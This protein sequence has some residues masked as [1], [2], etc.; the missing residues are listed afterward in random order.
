ML[1]QEKKNRALLAAFLVGLLTLAGG[2]VFATA[3]ISTMD[4]LAACIADANEAECELSDSFSFDRQLTITRD[5]TI[6]G[7]NKTLSRADGYAGGLFKVNAENTLTISE[8]T[9]DGG[10]PGWNRD[11]SKDA[12][13]FRF[14]ATGDRAYGQYTVNI[15]END[16]TSTASLITNDGTLKISDSSIKNNYVTA[17]VA[18]AISSTGPVEIANSTVQ[19]V[20]GN[21]VGAIFMKEVSPITIT[22]SNFIDNNSGNDNGS[23]Y[24]GA[25]H[26]NYGSVTVKDSVFKENTTTGNGGAINSYGGAFSV[27]NCV[28]ENNTIGNDGS[29]IKLG[30]G[31][32]QMSTPLEQETASITN[33]TF[34]GNLSLGY[35]WEDGT[36]SPNGTIANGNAEGTI[37]YYNDGYDEIIIKGDTFKD[38]KANWGVLSF[39]SCDSG[40]ETEYDC[41]SPIYTIEDTTF[42]DIDTVT[43]SSAIRVHDA[44]T[45]TV[46][47]VTL[48]NYNSAYGIYLSIAETINLENVTIENSDYKDSG[49]A[50]M[51]LVLRNA[52]VANINGLTYTNNTG[53]A[54]ID[55]IDEVNITNS[56]FADNVLEAP[57]RLL[58]NYKE[59]EMTTFNIDDTTIENNTASSTTGAGLII[60]NVT[61]GDMTVNI[62]DGV[63]IRNNNATN[64]TDSQDF[65]V[66]GGVSIRSD[67]ITNVNIASGA[68][69]E[70]NS[71]SKDGD[72]LYINSRKE[73][74]VVTVKLN[75]S[76]INGSNGAATD[77]A[78]T[79]N[80]IGR[81]GIKA[82][83]TQNPPTG[84]SIIVGVVMLSASLLVGYLI[85]SRAGRARI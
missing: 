35:Y 3:N 82:R 36:P 10:A 1:Q 33:S 20:G 26:S 39:Y 67:S 70:G 81:L 7:N 54:Y 55:R 69:I 53:E 6:R 9:I 34:S 73:N 47:N 58:P 24:G 5:V 62:G 43:S 56:Y 29:A 27:D 71:A 30:R 60:D 76:L 31:S 64:A 12:I 68:T 19:H 75:E 22:N 83:K 77:G 42:E 49:E 4:Q 85:I 17:G 23:S 13:S 11:L 28:F 52:N 57:L 41:V 78:I 65:G 37:S 45:I 84:D 61:V 38:E 15:A 66:G 8:L 72:D 44:D 25:I 63:V 18:S 21:S 16:K 50:M 2:D 48:R 80:G 46:K 59:G 32:S 51:G 14:N 40:T 79:I 74:S